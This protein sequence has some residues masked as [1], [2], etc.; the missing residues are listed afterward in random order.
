MQQTSEA[1]RLTDSQA[2]TRSTS[3][4]HTFYKFCAEDCMPAYIVLYAYRLGID[5]VS[6]YIGAE[7]LK[8]AGHLE[9]N[10]NEATAI[11]MG[12]APLAATG[13]ALALTI[14]K[15]RIPD[16]FSLF[17]RA[18]KCDSVGGLAYYTVGSMSLSLL[19]AMICWSVRNLLGNAEMNLGEML[20][21]S[22]VGNAVLFVPLVIAF[23]LILK[24]LQYCEAQNE[25]VM[26]QSVR[27]ASP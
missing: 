14:S 15:Y 11:A 10:S 7:I 17:Q 27:Q 6:A 8:N 1:T 9:Y 25:P 24:G 26:H 23:H 3:R 20:A 16:K 13:Y 19:G 22:A 12:G 2:T 18:T 4:S 5:V 21:S